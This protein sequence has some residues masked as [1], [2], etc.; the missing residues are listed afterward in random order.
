V[1][2]LVF[3]DNA[4]EEPWDIMEEILEEYGKTRQCHCSGH[5]KNVIAVNQIETLLK[6]I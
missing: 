5:W 4:V 2:E 6:H 3:E 1:S